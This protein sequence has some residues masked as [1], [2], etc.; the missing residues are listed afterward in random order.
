MNSGSN[1]HLTTGNTKKVTITN[2]YGPDASGVRDGRQ[3]RGINEYLIYIEL[4]AGGTMENRTSVKIW[5]IPGISVSDTNPAVEIRTAEGLAAMK[6]NLSG[7]YVLADDISV[8][9]AWT[10][11]GEEPGPFTGEFYG[12]GH[13]ITFNGSIGGAVYRGLFGYVQGASDSP[14]ALIRDLT[15]RYNSSA[16]SADAGSSDVHIGG[17]AGYIENT[18]VSNIITTGGTFSVNASGAGEIFLG[19]IA[20]YVKNSFI[21]NCRAELDVQLIRGGGIGNVGA[22]AGFTEGGSGGSITIN[23]NP[24]G[25]DKSNT[26]INQLA[27]KEV[28]VAAKVGGNTSGYALNIGGAVGSSFDNTMKDIIVSGGKVSFERTAVTDGTDGNGNTTAGGVTG[29]AVNSNMEA[30]SFNGG[31]F[32]GDNDIFGNIDDINKTAIYIGGLIGDCITNSGNVYINNCLAKGNIRF[33]E[34]EYEEKKIGN[35]IN[36][37]GVLGF[38][39]YIAGAEKVNITNCFFEDGIIKAVCSSGNLQAGGFC[40]GLYEDR[41]PG[42]SHSENTHNLNN[43]GAMAGTVEIEVR[44]YGKYIYAGGFVSQIWL[45]GI[46]SNCFSRANV[47]SKASGNNDKEGGSEYDYVHCTGGF[48]GVLAGGSTISSCYAT[49]TVQSEHNGDRNLTV[50]GLVGNSA[51]IIENCYALGNVSA[52]KTGGDWYAYAGGLVGGSWV[53]PDTPDTV[54]QYSF[55]AGQVIAKSALGGADAGGIAGSY[56]LINNTAALNEI[57]IAKGPGRSASRIAVDSWGAIG[58]ADNYAIDTMLVEIGDYDDDITIDVPVLNSDTSVHGKTT[59]IT[60]FLSAIWWQ[61]TLKFDNKVWDFST[62][63]VHRGYPLLK[64]L[65]GQQ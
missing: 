63:S 2:V 32:D 31:A 41:A 45:K 17:V 44:N 59:E 22:V 46:T 57:V 14:P 5:N 51:G 53:D 11:V 8:S 26:V 21:T 23:T 43:C 18:N 30:C 52:D 28:T 48:T 62:P 38:S 13:T 56:I 55:S 4:Y 50:G 64:G 25:K 60:I 58:L 65:S 7:L 24:P 35:N 61:R 29:Y 34:D 20:G 19:G 6:D 1:I 54:I 12:N 36:I 42:S 10:P 9:G 40:G 37:G 15:F 39:H 47:I 49:G 16:I 33:N 3:I 27:V